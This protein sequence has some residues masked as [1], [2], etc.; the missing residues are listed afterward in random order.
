MAEAN[1]PRR[2][3]Q[4]DDGGIG[5]A[6]GLRLIQSIIFVYDFIT[7]PIYYAYQ[8]PWKATE[9]IEPLCCSRG[10]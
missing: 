8:Q 6:V 4:P 3:Q 10:P 7:Y 2:V 5:V 9:A 1:Q